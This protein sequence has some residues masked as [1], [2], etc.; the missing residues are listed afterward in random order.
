MRP[1]Q[2]KKGCNAFAA[3]KCKKGCESPPAALNF[4]LWGNQ[5]IGSPPEPQAARQQ[6]LPQQQR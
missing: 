5:I 6:R 4:V 3:L 1:L 2:P